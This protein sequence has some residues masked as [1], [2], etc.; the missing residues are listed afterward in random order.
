ME[1]NSTMKKVKN[2]SIKVFD[3]AIHIDYIAN[4][5][6]YDASNKN[7]TPFHENA[8]LQ[9]LIQFTKETGK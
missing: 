2:I 4:K 5:E 6:L 7:F 1:E 3:D 9:N 8:Y